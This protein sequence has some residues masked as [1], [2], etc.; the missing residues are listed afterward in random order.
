MIITERF[1]FIHMH[2]TGGQTLN[3]IIERC[4]PRSRVIGYHFPRREIPAEH[5]ALPVVGLVRNPWDWYVSWYAFNQRP[6]VRNPLFMVMSEGGRLGFTATVTNLVNLGSSSPASAR[7]R[8]Q[9]I[10]LLPDNLED[11]RGIGLTRDDVRSFAD[12]SLGYYSWLFARMLG[13]HDAENTH[14]GKFEN[15]RQDF[16]EIMASLDVAETDAMA[17][18]LD[19]RERRN[20]SQHSHYSHYYDRPLRDLVAA[21]EARL[22][23]HHRYRFLHIGPQE[24]ELDAPADLAG[25]AAQPFRKLLGRARNYLLLNSGFDIERIRARLLQ[26]DAAKWGESARER[27]FDVHRDTEALLLVHFED[28]R[29]ESPE[30]RDLYNAFSDD[31]APAVD[32]IANYYRDNGFVVRMLFAKLRAGGTIP[33][34]VDGG[35]SLLNCHRVHIPI[36]TNG[37]MIFSVGDEEKVM[38]AGEFWEINN[39]LAHAVRNLGTQDRVH[40]IIDWMPNVEG[41]SE[42]EVLAGET[43][44]GPVKSNGETLDMMVASAHQLHRAGNLR[45]AESVYRQVL[46]IDKDHVAG[47][48]LI[49]LLCLQTRR[50]EEA[51]A[52]IGTALLQHPDDAQA[53]TNLALALKDLGRFEESAGHFHRALQLAPDNPRT[54]NN[55]GN[56]CLQLGRHI[57]AIESYR[58]ALAIDPA[59]AEAH[60]N[61][62]SVFLHLHRYTDAVESFGQT[63]ILQPRLEAARLGLVKALE[64]V[65]DAAAAPA[66]GNDQSR[67]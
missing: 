49:G 11:N 45:Q 14:V 7:H 13:A 64:G 58:R 57:D 15:L 47:N 22:I 33:R 67:L 24:H 53:H 10:D 29:Y 36:I 41:R 31:V 62:G 35:F 37:R 38:R 6:H 55:L 16:L 44:Q 8:Q 3:G 4:V 19:A 50:F 34:H 51:V 20:H 63:L 2:K 18:A 59:Y 66:P 32:F 9:L 23:E 27:R 30:Y 25:D 26:V 21:R 43:A 40:L 48:N 1:V 28:Y 61:L 52:Y 56:V 5:A 42:A 65:R 54:H 46:D 39:G 60:H 12:D 17:S